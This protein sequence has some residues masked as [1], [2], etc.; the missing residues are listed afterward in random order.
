MKDFYQW[1]RKRLNILIDNDKPAGGKWSFDEDNRRKLPKKALADIPTLPAVKLTPEIEQA[2]QSIEKEFPD[3]PGSLEHWF[4][5]LYTS[6]SP[7]D[8]TLSRMPSSA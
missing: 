1:Q 8:A 5:L 4:C 2:I 7:R 3:N 6:P